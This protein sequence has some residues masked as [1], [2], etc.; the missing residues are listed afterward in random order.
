M[1][2]AAPSTAPATAA[3]ESAWCDLVLFSASHL[4]DEERYQ[5]RRD[6]MDSVAAQQKCGDIPVKFFCSI[7]IGGDKNEQQLR[8]K[9]EAEIEART[10]AHPTW[11]LLLSSQPRSQ[12]EHYAALLQTTA[13]ASTSARMAQSW[14]AFVDDDDTIACGRLLKFTELIAEARSLKQLYPFVY[15]SGEP[16]LPPQDA[17]QRARAAR[18]WRKHHLGGEHVQV[19]VQMPALHFFVERVQPALLAHPMCDLFFMRML[20]LPNNQRPQWAFQ[21]PHTEYAY[22]LRPDSD[23][24]HEDT[25]TL[26][27]Q[28]ARHLEDPDRGDSSPIIF[29]VVAF[30]RDRW[31][32]LVTAAADGDILREVE[33]PAVQAMLVAPVYTHWLQHDRSERESRKEVLCRRCNQSGNNNM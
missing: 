19:A 7:S 24:N 20:R 27:Q 1:A 3:H 12:F 15:I 16:V 32:P 4:R 5:L 31:H 30:R 22:W 13:A 14:V 29:S 11:T 8:N 17:S 10:A 6:M 18:G 23:Q 26:Q 2:A 28:L 33:T 21:T 25:A 9:V